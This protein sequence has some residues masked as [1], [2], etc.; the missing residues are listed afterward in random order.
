MD[1]AGILEAIAPVCSPARKGFSI[2][3]SLLQYLQSRKVTVTGVRAT[4]IYSLKNDDCAW[5]VTEWTEGDDRKGMAIFQFDEKSALYSS[6]MHCGEGV[7]DNEDRVMRWERCSV[8]WRIGN[9]SDLKRL[10]G[11]A[12]HILGM[13]EWSVV[14]ILKLYCESNPAECSDQTYPPNLGFN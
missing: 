1:P 11:A 7:V 4:V 9:I 2:A 8:T 12:Q 10:F 14:D 5:T 13:L 6:L 3:Q